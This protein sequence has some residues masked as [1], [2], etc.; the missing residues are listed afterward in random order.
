MMMAKRYAAMA[1]ACGWMFCAFASAVPAGVDRSVAEF[2][3][4]AGEADDSGRLQRAIDM[5]SGGVIYVPAGTYDV[6]TTLVVTNHCSIL[7]HKN[8]IVKAVKPMEFVFKDGT[9]SLRMKG[10]GTMFFFR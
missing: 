10:G 4:A 6:A 7:M 1:A 3:R 5:T 2:S 8:A 9:L